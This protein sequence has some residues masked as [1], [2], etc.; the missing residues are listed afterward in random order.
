M[1]KTSGGGS[2]EAKQARTVKRIT[3]TGCMARRAGEAPTWNVEA[4]SCGGLE[5]GGLDE[6]V[7]LLVGKVII[8]CL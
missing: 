3:K 5:D 7:R 4:N 2:A 1:L 8:R 6:I